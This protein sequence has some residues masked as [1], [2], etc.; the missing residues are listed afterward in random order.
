[1]RIVLWIS[2]ILV[3]SFYIVGPVVDP[4]LWWHITV[5]KWIIAQREIPSVDHWNLFGAGLPW[6]AYSWSFEIPVAWIDGH[7]GESGLMAVK[8]LL[9]LVF[10]SSLSFVLGK[11]SRDWFFGI[12]LGVFTA[13]AAHD[14]L[15]LRPQTIVWILLVWVIFFAHEARCKGVTRKSL[16]PLCLLMC[17][18]ANL[19][20]TTILGLGTVSLWIWKDRPD[21]KIT[22][23]ILACF[24]ATLITPYMGGEWLTF[25]EKTNHPFTHSSI[26]EFQPANIM[27]FATGFLVISLIFLLSLCYF[28]PKGLSKAQMILALGFVLGAFAVI[29]FLPFAVIILASLSALLWGE[30]QQS[31]KS[32]GNIGEGLKRLEI[33]SNRI[34]K[35]GL[36][37]VLLCLAFMNIYHLNKSPVHYGTVPK[38]AVDFIQEQQL[39]H[40]ILHDFGRGGYM[41]YRF[42]D[43]QGEVKNRVPIDG[44]TNVTPPEILEKAHAALF[45]KQNWKDYLNAVKPETILWR[46]ESSLSAILLATGNWCSVFQSGTME[47]GFQ[48]FTKRSHSLCAPTPQ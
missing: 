33:L 6:R 16:I 28:N 19:H 20:I 34:P 24:L 3:T 23:C 29:K 27:Q 13:C 31:D 10:V 11:I 43:S 38:D 26:A 35:E 37:F 48:V 46:S 9:S 42:S 39:A 18:W 30:C 17:V 4:D 25:I 45:G 14:H 44:R 32:F 1:M 2:L 22:L 36:S 21:T 7:F 41:M 47:Q 40:P 15:T 12:L 5:G 8:L